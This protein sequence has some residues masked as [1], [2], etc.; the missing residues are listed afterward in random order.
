[1]DIS[2]QQAL[3]FNSSPM[4]ETR[5]T[6]PSLRLFRPE[7][8]NSMSPFFYGLC[9]QRHFT[10]VSVH[11]LS[12]VVFLPQWSLFN[13]FIRSLL[14]TS[15]SRDTHA[16]I[17]VL[18]FIVRCWVTPRSLLRNAKVNISAVSCHATI[19]ERVFAVRCWVTRNSGFA[20]VNAAI[21]AVQWLVHTF[22]QFPHGETR[23]SIVVCSTVA[24]QR[25]Q[26][27]TCVRC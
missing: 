22:Q 9:L 1:V 8:P 17:E 11:F 6:A 7:Q 25:L 3:R 4:G 2:L 26:E 14:K 27:D 24:M 23:H 12:A 21:V 18:V 15:S 13:R 20:V 16:T 10:V 5:H 19:E